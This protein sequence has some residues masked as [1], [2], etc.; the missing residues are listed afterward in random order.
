MIKFYFFL[1]IFLFHF[2]HL[3]GQRSVYIHCYN[4]QKTNKELNDIADE[5]AVSLKKKITEI[6]IIRYTNENL[7]ANENRSSGKTII[8]LRELKISCLDN[9][10]QII[11]D[12]IGRYKKGV[13]ANNMLIICNNTLN[14][15]TKIETFPLYNPNS[16]SITKKISDQIKLNKKKALNF[17]VIIPPEKSEKPVVKFDKKSVTINSG[18]STTLNPIVQGSQIVSYEWSPIVGLS[19]VDC[20]KPTANPTI[21]KTYSLKVKDISGCQSDACSIDVLVNLSDE[22]LNKSSKNNSLEF[23]KKTYNCSQDDITLRLINEFEFNQLKDQIGFDNVYLLY[24]DDDQ[25][26]NKRSL[27]ILK[28][29]QSESNFVYEIPPEV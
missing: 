19:C 2:I 15:D 12:D 23:E 28:N 6:N 20:E 1:I 21:S 16:E 14:C 26:C 25:G 11:S 22:P 3:Y 29:T 9:A 4:K 18:E 13:D 27:Q 5:I 17:I 24:T 8:T 7:K 10:C